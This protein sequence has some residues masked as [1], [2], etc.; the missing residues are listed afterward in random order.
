MTLASVSMNA[1]IAIARRTMKSMPLP[2]ISAT[3]QHNYQ[4]YSSS[5]SV[6]GCLTV[7]VSSRASAISQ[8]SVKERKLLSK[9]FHRLALLHLELIEK[10][11]RWTL[12]LSHRHLQ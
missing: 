5:S 6:T 7:V 4:H 3:K 10:G 11:S 1:V 9:L 2:N 12:K 8:V